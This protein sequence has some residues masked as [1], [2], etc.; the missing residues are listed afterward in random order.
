MA[1]FDRA[2]FRDFAIR[3][4]ELAQDAPGLVDAAERDRMTVI[5]RARWIRIVRAAETLVDAVQDAA[6]WMAEVE[7]N[8]V[9]LMNDDAPPTDTP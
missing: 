6:M 2:R 7:L 9:V 5:E 8:A 1:D 4:T 3:A